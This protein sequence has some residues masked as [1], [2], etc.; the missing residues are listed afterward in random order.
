M[1]SNTPFA[2][3]FDSLVDRGLL[4][5]I[6]WWSE[7]PAESVPTVLPLLLKVPDVQGCNIGSREMIARSGAVVVYASIVVGLRPRSRGHHAH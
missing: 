1:V 6:R 4:V 7:I 2:C 5:D 3:P